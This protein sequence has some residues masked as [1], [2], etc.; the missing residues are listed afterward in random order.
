MFGSYDD[1]GSSCSGCGCEMEVIGPPGPRHADGCPYKEP[2]RD[3]GPNLTDDEADYLFEHILGTDLGF[4]MLGMSDTKRRG[5]T[6]ALLR[7]RRGGYPLRL[8]DARVGDRFEM[9]NYKG[10]H[11]RVR[12][13]EDYIIG[14]NRVPVTRNNID[15]AIRVTR[16][17]DGH[18]I[19]VLGPDGVVFL[20][21]GSNPIR[22]AV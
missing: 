10:I 6:D 21:F 5:V 4:R 15:Q 22:P 9:L 18:H 19:P 1:G 8:S 7:R 14:P 12:L 2:V 20:M 17:G 11:T 3:E 16:D 13:P